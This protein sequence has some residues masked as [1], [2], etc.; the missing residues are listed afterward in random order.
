M[1][2]DKELVLFGYKVTFEVI[3]T[4]KCIVFTPYGRESKFV[5]DGKSFKILSKLE[6]LRDKKFIP[7]LLKN[8]K[9]YLKKRLEEDL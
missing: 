2:S 6:T 7:A 4:K 1:S 5:V 9:E 3:D 8:N